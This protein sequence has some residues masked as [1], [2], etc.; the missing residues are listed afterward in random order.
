MDVEVFT[1]MHSVCVSG[2]NGHPQAAHL[3]GIVQQLVLKLA[4]IEDLLEHLVELLF[5]KDEL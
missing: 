2:C 3:A 4:D 5:T 1:I